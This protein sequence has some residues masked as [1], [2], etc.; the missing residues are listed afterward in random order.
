MTDADTRHRAVGRW[1]L[2]TDDPDPGLTQAVFALLLGVDLVLRFAGE[3]D[4]ALVSWPAAA[5]ALTVVTSVVACLT[6][7]SRLPRSAVGLL[8]VL[9]IAALGMSRLNTDGSGAGILAVVPALWLGRQFGRAGA[10]VVALSTVLLMAVPGLLYLG[11]GGVNLSRSLLVPAVTT[12]AALALASSLELV[13]AR[14]D[15]AEA[16]GREL[17]GALDTIEHQRRFADAILDT[18]D[19]GLVLLDGDGAYRAINRRHQE[20]MRLAY[21]GGHAG[22]AGQLGLVYAED[23][24]TPLTREEMP[25]VR[26]H[27]GEEF[28]DSRMWIGHD[29]LTSRAVSVSARTVRDEQGRVTGAALAYKDV[30]QFMRALAVKDEFVASVSHELRTPLTSIVGYVNLLQEREDLPGQVLSQL[31]VVARN[32][33]RLQRLVADLLHTAQVDEGPMHVVRTRTDL[34]QIV[35]DAV[36]AATPAARLCGITV[37]A[38]VPERLELMIDAQRIAQVVDNLLSNAI[39]YT[40]DGGRVCVRLELDGD[41]ADLAVT[42]TGIG[43]APADKDRLFTRFFRARHAE[44]QSIQGVGLG[45]SITKSIVESHGGRIEVDSEIGRGSTFR[46]RL[47]LE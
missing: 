45:L 42:D 18:V 20:F 13:R 11:I 35:R 34:S 43:I 36:H 25:T 32:T 23:G 2:L 8:P 10:V 39:K 30:T 40:L 3:A 6:P 15:E 14:R 29:P 19:V 24:S 47:P 33:D 22:R 16:R 27:R 4:L 44:E 5:I 7:W 1:L 17:A 12:W 21:P 28:D 37:E 26:A 41:R 38:D 46:V 9:D 31:D